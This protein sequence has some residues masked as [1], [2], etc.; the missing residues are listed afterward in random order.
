MSP[1]M[2]RICLLLHYR[3]LWWNGSATLKRITLIKMFSNLKMILQWPSF[4]SNLLK[5]PK[6]HFWNFGTFSLIKVWKI[7]CKN[8]KTYANSCLEFFFKFSFW[9]FNFHPLALVSS[10]KLQLLLMKKTCCDFSK[11]G[12]KTP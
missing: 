11:R 6:A 3:T 2:W 9:I 5:N 12:A 4:I 7:L 1:F 8:F 10:R